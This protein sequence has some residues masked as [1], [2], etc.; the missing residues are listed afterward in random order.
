MLAFVGIALFALAWWLSLRL[1]ETR[2]LAAAPAAR[3][4]FEAIEPLGPTS[5]RRDAE[6]APDPALLSYGRFLVAIDDA[7]NTVRSNWLD[8]SAVS[9]ARGSLR[10]RDKDYNSALAEF[11][12]AVEN[13]PDDATARRGRAET[14]IRLGRQAEAVRDYERL[15]ALHAAK[16]H[17]HYNHGVALCRVNRLS[18]AADRFR[19]T[20]ELEPTHDRAL[21]NLASIAQQQGKLN[22]AVSLWQQVCR[23]QPGM[24]SAWFNLGMLHS[25]LEQWPDAVACFREVINQHAD[26]A[27]AR[28]NLA[29]ALRA[30]GKYDD[31]ITQLQM[32]LDGRP[33]DRAALAEL[34]DLHRFLI[35]AKSNAAEHRR[36]AVELAR[37]ALRLDPNQPELRRFVDES[38]SAATP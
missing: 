24:T 29:I 1:P 34:I 32:T 21:F 17:D 35:D 6:P 25:E 3:P 31:A 10:L 12:R 5:Q 22:E 33:D 9:M 30:G 18:D 38:G 11:D 23:R 28:I 20:L 13:R 7:V 16:A 36:A 4:L 2:P 26:D 19:A 37:R 14:L 15:E 27:T 8:R